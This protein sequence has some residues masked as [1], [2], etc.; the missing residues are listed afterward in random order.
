MLSVLLFSKNNPVQCDLALTS[1]FENLATEKQLCIHVIYTSAEEQFT[2]GYNKIASKFSHNLVNF[3]RVRIGGKTSA[4]K[5]LFN[6][7]SQKDTDDLNALY[8]LEET[9]RTIVQSLT[10]SATLLMYDE[11]VIAKKLRLSN[12]IINLVTVK[13]NDSL[14]SLRMGLNI[15]QK[16]LNIRDQNRYCKWD[17]PSSIKWWSERFSIEGTLYAT[18][19]L[20]QLFNSI[21]FDSIEKLVLNANKL[22]DRKNLFFEGFCYHTSKSMKIDVDTL[23]GPSYE[24]MNAVLL[25]DYSMVMPELSM[26]SQPIIQVKNVR[27]YQHDKPTIILS[28]ESQLG[29]FRH[30]LIHNPSYRSYH[31]KSRASIIN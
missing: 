6:S 23:Y 10:S 11:C 14:F 3:H 9:T 22:S 29:M 21:T 1:L 25:Q 20:R 15:N 26:S 28:P 12:E 24:D 16:P 8:R 13:P 18:S 5:R 31:A 27:F 7:G 17:V 4:L 2:L 19:A 30:D